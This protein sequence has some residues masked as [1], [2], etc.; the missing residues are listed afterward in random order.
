MSLLPFRASCSPLS[1]LVL[2]CLICT[3]FLTYSRPCSLQVILTLPPAQSKLLAC[4]SVAS[5]PE[6]RQS[7]GAIRSE[8]LD[9]HPW[10]RFCACMMRIGM[11][12]RDR[13]APFP[14]A[15]PRRSKIFDEKSTHDC[16][17]GRRRPGW[18][19]SQAEQRDFLGETC[20]TCHFWG[21]VSC[22]RSG[23][24]SPSSTCMVDHP[25]LDKPCLVWMCILHALPGTWP[26]TPIFYMYPGLVAVL[27]FFVASASMN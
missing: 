25:V 1:P 8:P 18:N 20:R 23:R 24:L 9:S 14:V 27:F 7:C 12:P 10:T 6:D 3:G 17:Q 2:E 4:S 11:D 19:V 22:Q 21:P 13:V 15:N 26:D 16:R 5:R